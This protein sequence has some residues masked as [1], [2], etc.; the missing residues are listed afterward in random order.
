MGKLV[1][2]IIRGYQVVISPVIKAITANARACRF[3]PS[4]SEYTI[5]SVRR[6][7]VVK[8]LRLGLIQLAHCH[9]F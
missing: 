4:C 9:P 6:Y 1:I 5:Q 7:G 3:T 8:G 2:L